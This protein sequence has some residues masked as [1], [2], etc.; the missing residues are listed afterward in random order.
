MDQLDDGNLCSPS[1]G[2]LP[3]LID[4]SYCF[5][6]LSS[7]GEP[8]EPFGELSFFKMIDVFYDKAHAL[9]GD[10]C[11]AFLLEDMA[12]LAELRAAVIACRRFGKPIAVML[13]AD[14]GDYG[15]RQSR[16]LAWMIT[17]QKMG[18]RAFGIKSSEG[19]DRLEELFR[20]LYP[21]AESVLF[22]RLEHGNVK[23]SHLRRL[24][25]CGAEC[26]DCRGIS[27]AELEVVGIELKRADF[28]ALLSEKE[29]TSFI[30][31][32]DRQAFFLNP[33]NITFSPQIDIECDMAEE[34]VDFEDEAYDCISILITEHDDGFRFSQNVHFLTVPIIFSTS[35]EEA[36]HM[37]LEYYNGR[38]LVDSRCGINEERLKAIA[39]EFGAIV[40]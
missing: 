9:D 40:Y 12:S 35:V 37:A 4:E 31:A 17:L 22:A 27:P 30:A 18:V 8:C 38:A 7:L 23:V 6:E 11:S 34:L 10:G 39:D 3:R 15:D 32:N 2:E 24:I 16:E 20:D 29:D 1:D 36:L 13:S 21:Y 19:I 5:G 14:G 26:F 33:E 28:G 25:A